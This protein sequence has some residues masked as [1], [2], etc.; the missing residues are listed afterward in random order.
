[1]CNFPKKVPHLTTHEITICTTFSQLQV[2]IVSGLLARVRLEVVDRHL[3]RL[4]LLDVLQAVEHQVVVERICSQGVNGIT[5]IAIRESF[6]IKLIKSYPKMS[7]Y[8]DTSLIVT[9]FCSQTESQYRIITVFSDK[10][11][12]ASL[13]GTTTFG[14]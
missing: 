1:M 10:I 14:V 11:I 8:C 9:L 5:M 3:G 2:N 4:G 12:K 6:N 13:L 7:G